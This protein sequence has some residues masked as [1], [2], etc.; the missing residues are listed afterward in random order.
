MYRRRTH[1]THLTDLPSE[2]IGRILLHSLAGGEDEA[3]HTLRTLNLVCRDFRAVWK[4][5]GAAIASCGC[6]HVIHE[7]S[8]PSPPSMFFRFDESGE[9]L[10]ASSSLPLTSPSSKAHMTTSNRGLPLF[11][12]KT[13]IST[14]LDF[15]FDDCDD[16]FIHVC[17]TLHRSF[18]HDVI[19]LGD[20]CLTWNN[21][22]GQ[23]IRLA[24]LAKDV[25]GLTAHVARRSLTIKGTRTHTTRGDGSFSL[26]TPSPP[27][28]N[29]VRP[30]PVSVAAAASRAA[31][32]PTSPLPPTLTLVFD[33]NDTVDFNVS[34]FQRFVGVRRLN[35]VIGALSVFAPRMMTTDMNVVNVP[36]LR[37]VYI[38]Y[39]GDI[40]VSRLQAFWPVP[41][42]TGGNIERTL[43][44]DRLHILS[45]DDLLC[46]ERLVWR[47]PLVRIRVAQS[48][49]LGVPCPYCRPS[50][51]FHH[52]FFRRLS[53]LSATTLSLSSLASRRRRPMHLSL[54][55]D[56]PLQYVDA[57]VDAFRAWI[58]GSPLERHPPYPY[59]VD[60]VMLYLVHPP[61]SDID[62]CAKYRTLLSGVA[63]SMPREVNLVF[64]RTLT[65][66]CPYYPF[67][68]DLLTTEHVRLRTCTLTDLRDSM[69]GAKN[70]RELLLVV[71]DDCVGVRRRTQIQKGE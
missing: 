25:L 33:D 41:E 32:L 59:D 8:S 4:K 24:A 60:T 56:R 62:T 70:V 21:Y 40:T 45:E 3:T 55:F 52:R 68:Y 43:H 71:E 47:F 49:V 28:A 69:H 14:D 15:D 7:R 27:W 10:D 29:Q 6:L 44:V 57:F 5:N 35:V 63:E 67:L 46:L 12:R 13:Y 64:H 54:I 51:E 17:R 16:A 20:A 53:A 36:T 22:S 38:Q 9:T 50:R 66:T 1:L 39:A 65:R 48:L 58:G 11:V 37:D 31:S 61:H 19:H 34:M 42:A 23:K 2:V 26:S 30:T 18:G